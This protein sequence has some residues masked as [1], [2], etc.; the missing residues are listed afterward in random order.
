[1]SVADGGLRIKPVSDQGYTLEHLLS[2][3]TAEDAH[4]EIT[5]GVPRGKEAW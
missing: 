5:T 4:D 3:V 2:G 1:M